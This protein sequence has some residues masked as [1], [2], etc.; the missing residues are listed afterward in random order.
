MCQM[1]KSTEYIVKS[2][3]IC[4]IEFQIVSEFQHHSNSDE[5]E[6]NSF[7]NSVVVAILYASYID[8]DMQCQ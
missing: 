2:A 4:N 5:I 8:S 7:Q 3:D 6:L 1:L